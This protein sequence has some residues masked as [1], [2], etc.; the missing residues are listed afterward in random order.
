MIIKL[1]LVIAFILLS[2]S[3]FSQTDTNKVYESWEI[4]VQTS[5]PG[6]DVA[7][8]QF[9]DENLKYPQTDIDISGSIYIRFVIS[10]T[11]E[12]V[13]VQVLRGIYPIFDDE[14]V[15]VVKS[16]PKFNPAKLNGEFVNCWYVVPIKFTI[17]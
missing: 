2:F 4:D 7:L 17:Y 8:K 5:F 1:F 6:G 3:T 12:I 14:A 13:E 15:K 11:G 16:F 10:K 9:I